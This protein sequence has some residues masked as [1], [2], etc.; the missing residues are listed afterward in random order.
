MF[1]FI[2]SSSAITEY[3]S[4]LDGTAFAIV[5]GFRCHVVY[6]KCVYGIFC[7]RIRLVPVC[8]GVEYT[9]CI[10][11]HNN[12][13]KPSDRNINTGQGWQYIIRMTL[14]PAGTEEC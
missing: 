3:G 1:S 2:T 14:G 8:S 7:I 12:Y 5:A 13:S 11:A 6:N 9:I 4:V 10:D